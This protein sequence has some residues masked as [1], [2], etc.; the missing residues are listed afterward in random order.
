[1]KRKLMWATAALTLLVLP[2]G[3]IVL[4]GTTAP[5]APVPDTPQQPVA[6]RL[7]ASPIVAAAVEPHTFPETDTPHW[8]NDGIV[9]VY[10]EPTTFDP[11]SVLDVPIEQLILGEAA[12][13]EASAN[14]LTS[15]PVR[16]ELSGVSA[17]LPGEDSTMAL[18]ELGIDTLL[19]SE[20]FGGSETPVEGGTTGN[21]S[22]AAGTVPDGTPAGSNVNDP[23]AAKPDVDTGDKPDTDGGQAAEPAK[24]DPKKPDPKENGA[25]KLDEEEDNRERIEVSLIR[26][27]ENVVKSLAEIIVRT[28][29]KGLKR[30]FVLVR[31]RQKDAPWWVQDEA[32]RQGG[33]YFRSRAQFGNAKTL[34]GARFR[35]VVAFATGKDDVPEA[36]VFF[37]EIPLKY[38]LSQEFDMTLNRD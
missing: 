22:S 26:P 28:R 17:G 30:S 31:A 24:P 25:K 21:D 33:T 38:L 18:A 13:T 36:G 7:D 35:M 11:S 2:I 1:M 37:D 19:G 20:F 10:E 8:A 27:Q 9:S 3:V 4:E 32:V 5:G 29:A 12:S 34:D 23:D 15:V 16:P 14:A 6:G